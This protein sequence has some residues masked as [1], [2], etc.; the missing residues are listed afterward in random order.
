MGKPIY[1]IE[2][3]DDDVIVLKFNPLGTLPEVQGLT[4][5]DATE[6]GLTFTWKPVESAEGYNIKVTD[7]MGQL[8]MQS[9]SISL[10]NY[11]V[12]G[13]EP[14]KTYGFSI[15]AISDKYRNSEWSDVMW[16]CQADFVDGLSD[17]LAESAETVR[18][19]DMNGIVLKE[20]KANQI[21]RQGIPDGIYV[22]KF[23]NG[24]AKKA[25]IRK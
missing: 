9:D 14:S 24:L 11:N 10:S 22:I 5:I 2:E 12:E 20:C 25:L 8:V 18:V 21:D 19:C 3:R 1:D 15:Q 16:L 23:K 4:P 13:L 7:E 17:N 6:T